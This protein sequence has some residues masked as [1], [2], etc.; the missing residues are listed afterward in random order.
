M[1]SNLLMK[2]K[3]THLI[4]VGQLRTIE[5]QVVVEENPLVKTFSFHDDLCEKAIPGQFVMVW[6]PGIDEVPMSLSSIEKDYCSITV[7]KVGDA[8]KAL[9]KMK[10]GDLIG[11]RGPFGK[12]FSFAKGKVLVVG[13]GTG[14]SPLAVLA[15]NLSRLRASVTFL[16]GAE[17]KSELLFLN[18]VK[19]VSANVI[20]TTND[21]S[22]GLK[23]FVTEPAEKMLAENRFDMVYAC[24]P[25]PMMVKM[26]LLARK[27]NVP[28]QMSLE[29]LMRCGVGLCGSCVIGIYRICKDGP[30]FT[31]RQL[32]KVQGEFGRFK[33]DF[34]GREIAV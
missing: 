27:Y 24:G 9:H 3:A 4:S 12:G 19:R 21:G 11:V 6:I 15:E 23:G 34:D 32:E 30:V 8:T 18:R 5:I 7:A 2:N 26:L 20:A 29:R 28:L 31:G 25:E 14:L 17:T 13:G 1:E 10:K 16:L 22:F 33:R